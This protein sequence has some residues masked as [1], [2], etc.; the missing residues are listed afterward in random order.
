MYVASCANQ[1]KGTLRVLVQTYCSFS[2]SQVTL[3]G[4][5]SNTAKRLKTED[6][7][8][9]FWLHLQKHVQLQVESLLKQDGQLLVW[10]CVV[11]WNL[12]HVSD[13]D[14]T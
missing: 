14:C 13:T 5:F 4:Y 6:I 8:R 3:M 2:V 11:S 10:D 1:S 7:Y 9:Q 12:T